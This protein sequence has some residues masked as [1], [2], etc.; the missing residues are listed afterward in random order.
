MRKTSLILAFILLIGVSGCDASTPLPAPGPVSTIPSDTVPAPNSVPRLTSTDAPEASSTQPIPIPSG[1]RVVYLRDGNLWSWTEAGGSVQLTGTGDMSI[2]RLSDD[3]QLLAYMRGREISTVHMDGTDVHLLTSLE[4]EGAALWFA[5]SGSMLA[6]STSDHIEVVDLSAGSSTR[7]VTYPAIPTG[8][9]PEVVWTPDAAGF[10]TV[11]PPQSESG[12]AELLFVFTDG[13]VANL[14]KFSMVS[15]SESPPY[16]SPDGGY[17]IYAAKL[18]SENKSLY[19]MD[20]SGATRP[21]GEPM[22][23]VR[24][25]AWLPDSVHFAYGEGGPSNAYMGSVSGP[26]TMLPFSLPSGLRWVDAEHYLALEN[27][28]LSLRDL[29]GKSIP[30]DSNVQGFDFSR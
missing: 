12:Q 16:I 29:N 19:L 11:I 3:G 26:P 21:Y 22:D 5:P 4:N 7:V 1:L 18:D 27:G 10:K 23:R 15:P 17:I 14:A 25:Y 20:S 30:I 24:A 8:Y 9:Y 6:I 28:S 2:A 13:T